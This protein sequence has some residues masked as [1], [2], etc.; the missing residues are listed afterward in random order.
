LYAIGEYHGFK[1]MQLT[2]ILQKLL[3]HATE[4]A[5]LVGSL[6]ARVVS[7]ILV[8]ALAED[9]DAVVHELSELL[10]NL[11]LIAAPASCPCLMC[12]TEFRTRCNAWSRN[13]GDADGYRLGASN[14]EVSSISTI[15]R[16]AGSADTG[17]TAVG[18]DAHHAGDLP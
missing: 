14:V 1:I 10:G 3:K 4:A 7:A 13:V 6:D 2:F 16:W 18:A 8:T 5:R 9:V 15:R 12:G 11:H 17:S